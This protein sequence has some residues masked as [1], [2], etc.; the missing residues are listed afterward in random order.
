[1]VVSGR[2]YFLQQ[3]FFILSFIA[4]SPRS[5]GQ[6][7]RN[8]ATWLETCSLYKCWSKNLG[9]CPPKNF[10]REKHAKF[11]PILDPFSLWA[12]ISLERIKISKI[13]KL[14]D[15]QCFLP[16]WAKKFGELWS[17]N[18]R[19]LEVQLYPENRIFWNTIFRPLGG[20]ASWNSYA[21]ECASLASLYPIVDGGFSNNFFKGGQKLALIQCISAYNFRVRGSNLMKL[22]HMTDHK[23]TIITYIQHLGGTTPLKFGKAKNV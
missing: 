16:R 20:A 3:F 2:P 7:L 11:G 19:D 18:Y 23:E 21:I 12:R 17:T 9:A 8:F 5:M 4:R 13:G 10:G 15:W 1:M 6:S 14:F 22:C